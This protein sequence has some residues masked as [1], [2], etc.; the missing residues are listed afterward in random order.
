METVQVSFE[1]R[2][3]FPGNMSSTKRHTML[4]AHQIIDLHRVFAR[5]R[6]VGLCDDPVRGPLLES[7]RRQRECIQQR[8]SSGTQ[9]L[10]RND[11]ILEWPPSVR[12]IYSTYSSKKKIVRIQQFTKI[13]APHGESG[14]GTRGCTR[15]A[16]FDPFFGPEEEKL[17][18][19]CIETVRNEDRTSY[20]SAV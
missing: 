2:V 4:C 6:K 16:P 5:V 13:T 12:V 15:L 9:T 19:A 17:V 11:V 3:E 8:T 20:V 14:H 10:F 18:T 7:G 1:R